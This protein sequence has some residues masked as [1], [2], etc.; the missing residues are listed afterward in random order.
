MIDIKE[1]TSY[2][3]LYCFVL[4][5]YDDL[6]G[7]NREDGIEDVRGDRKKICVPNTFKRMYFINDMDQL[8]EDAWC[9]WLYKSIYTDI[10]EDMEKM[11]S[12]AIDIDVGNL[13]KDQDFLEWVDSHEELL[14]IPI[15]RTA[16]KHWHVTEFDEVDLSHHGLGELLPA[17]SV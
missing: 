3:Q 10:G 16:V 15:F 11:V 4:H 13:I 14:N 6:M 5:L 8:L 9:Y 12:D 1:M 17:A 7:E 2:E